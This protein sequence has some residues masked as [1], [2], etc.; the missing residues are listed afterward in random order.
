MEHMI[1]A[2]RIANRA[3][4]VLLTSF[5]VN[6]AFADMHINKD[7]VAPLF[8]NNKFLTI[9]GDS[10]E[11]KVL[12]LLNKD[13][14]IVKKE[15]IKEK[16][17][18]L[19]LVKIDNE[20]YVLSK[21][22]NLLILYR[23]DE[24]DLK[25]QK[26][27][28][29]SFDNRDD[30]ILFPNFFENNYFVKN[31]QIYFRIGLLG[32]EAIPALAIFDPKRKTTGKI[33]FQ[34][35][36]GFMPMRL[37]EFRGDIMLWLRKERKPENSIVVKIKGTKIAYDI[38]YKDNGSIFTG[39]SQSKT[40]NS[41]LFGNCLKEGLDFCLVKLGKK[42]D[43]IENFSIPLRPILY[44]A[45]K[46]SAIV[47]GVTVDRNFKP[48]AYV[49]CEKKDLPKKLSCKMLDNINSFALPI[50]VEAEDN[51]KY[52]GIYF[53]TEN[54]TKVY[55]LNENGN[56][57]NSFRLG[58]KLTPFLSKIFLANRDLYIWNTKNESSK[59][60]KLPNDSR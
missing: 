46:S 36:A 3:V 15:D 24:A 41:V 47:Y 8:F 6:F 21:K 25:L 30:F 48:T 33:V 13:F 28:S 39:V 27:G 50:K 35:F 55:I 56:I 43:G 38:F 1:V 19:E 44:F 17:K 31:G 20:L 49:R 40:G 45:S 11:N 9:C 26:A 60:M 34:K 14:T 51:K 4:F 58:D 42:T 59:F 53:E 23:L 32:K 10:A 18:P 37:F 5:I 22:D 29:V 57:Y 52:F 2:V 12:L 16:F 7:C 54:G